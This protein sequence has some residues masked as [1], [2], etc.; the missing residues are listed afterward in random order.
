MLLILSLLF[1]FASC[2][3]SNTSEINIG[4]TVEFGEYEQNPYEPGKEKIQWI[5]VDI[6]N[7]KSLLMSR[8]AIE[9]MQYADCNIYEKGVTWET[10]SLRKWL[11]SEFYENSFTK[12][13][14]EYI[15]STTVETKGNPE[16]KTSGGTPRRTD[17]LFH[18]W[19]NLR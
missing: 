9:F 6:Q 15:I 16:Y 18:L 2:K 19:M 14:K 1:S 7:D 12:Q 4:D 3:N 13:E 11:N 5:V 10:S 8:Y 17:Y